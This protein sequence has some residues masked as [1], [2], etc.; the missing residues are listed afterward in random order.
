[1]NV[2]VKKG[3]SHSRFILAELDEAGKWY[4]DGTMSYLKDEVVELPS[5]LVRYDGVMEDLVHNKLYICLKNYIT[6]TD[7]E[8]YAIVFNEAKA[9]VLVPTYCLIDVSSE[10]A[11][12]EDIL[13]EELDIDSLKEFEEIIDIAKLLTFSKEDEGW[14]IKLNF[15]EFFEGQKRKQIE[16][17]I[18]F[19][20][21][22]KAKRID[23]NI[24]IETLKSLTEKLL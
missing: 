12:M 8:E 11:F 18:A 17:A 7:G 10:E 1:M 19:K 4:H 15:D 20:Q 6:G 21:T 5:K 3:K 2:I 13:K 16:L 14:D 24:A 22:L 9:W 23:Q